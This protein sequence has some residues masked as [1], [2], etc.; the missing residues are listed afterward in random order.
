VLD[1]ALRQPPEDARLPDAAQEQKVTALRRFLFPFRLARSRLGAGGERLLL[2]AVGIVAGSA[3]IAAVLS[4]RLVMQDRALAQAT[5][6]L[7]P[8]DRSLEVAWFGAFGGT[9]RSL[10]RDVTK[11]LGREPV[12]AMLYRESQ[13]QGRLVNLRAAND[14]GKYVH[15]RSGR[16]PRVCVPTHCEVLRLETAGPVP[17]TPSLRLIQVGTAT[18]LPS[19]PFAA[20]IQPVQ[21]EQVARAVRY[22][23]PQPSP[24]LIAD[25]VNGMS[26]TSELS[27]FYRSYAWFVPVAPGDVHPWS[28][29][30][31]AHSIE[32]LRSELGA[33]SDAFQVT[34]PTD[35]LTAAVASSRVAARRLLLL[36]GETGALLLAFTVLA[37]AALRRDVAEARRRLSWA[38]ARR[39]QVELHTFAETGAVALAGTIAG[40]FLGALVASFVAS[41]AGSPAWQ[42]VEHSLLTGGGLATAACLAVA[43]ALLLYLT[44]RVSTV[45]VGRLSITPLDVAAIAATAIVVV[46]YARGSID[47][48]SLAH[49]GS[50]TF[51]LLVP[52]LVT[53]ACAVGAVRLL[54]PGLRALGRIGRGGPLPLRLAALSL[55]RNPGQA[56][57]IATFLVASLGLA[58]FAVSYRATL[59]QGQHDEAYYAVPAPYV[60]TEDLAQLVPVLHGWHGAPATQV[61][62]L[63]GN[64]TSTTGFTFLGVPDRRLALPSAFRSLRLPPGR[65]FELPVSTHG[66]D[67]AVRAWFRSPLGDFQAVTLGQTD[68]AKRV[69]LHGKIPFA[70]AT[71]SSLELDAINSGRISANAGTGLQP[72]ARGQLKLGTPSVG[73]TAIPHAFADWSGSGGVTS[74][75]AYSLSPDRTSSFRPHEPTDGL[76]LPVLA[77]PSVA[78]AADRN[79]VVALTIE[80]EQVPARIVGVVPRYE[81][82]VGDAVVADRRTAE[83][84]LDSRSPGLG[85]TSELWADALP[86]Q[87]PSELTVVSRADVLAQLRADPL[88]RGA[89]AT[90]A[91]TAALALALALVGLVLGVAG[92]RRDERGELFDLEAQGASP[93]TLRSHLRLRALL[94]A[95]FG[96]VGGIVTGA[97]LSRLVLSLVTVT[98]SAAKPEPPLRLVVDLP[99]LAAAVV[100]Y[101]LLAVVLVGLAT[102]LGGRSLERSAEAAA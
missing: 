102:R 42:V 16:L 78:A 32:Q 65:V 14:L 38:G 2:V 21:T 98:A 40:W 34:G 31:Y 44:V 82:I 41:Q 20:W 23:A 100:V 45:D 7:A 12:R 36:G 46:G 59:L 15:L 49:G 51:V 87:K 95:A 80:G 85:T 52:A 55:A 11:A 47:A 26:S 77:T 30:A 101:A 33:Q 71:L 90:L 62:R 19:A 69:L 60:V 63:S 4:G 75:L 88:A 89:L 17:S 8:A 94:V 13:I 92:D 43:S 99:V 67:V 5:T 24:V 56:T 25:G 91:A 28:I 66:D 97:I 50:G 86:A 1:A 79:G 6:R 61:L 18:L 84:V 76:P 9:W 93:A 58:L 35:A 54:L 3:A 96:L 64:V 68:G 72:M 22:H 37:A 74:T 27:S 39:W 73:G 81:S 29:D 53:F 48:G 10:D 83:T 57:V 70:H